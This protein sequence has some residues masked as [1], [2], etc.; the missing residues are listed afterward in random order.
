[1]SP[2]M[3]LNR[4]VE[5]TSRMSAV[6]R[7]A[8]MPRP[9]GAP[10]S[11]EISRSRNKTAGSSWR[12]KE[13]PP[14]QSLATVIPSAERWRAFVHEALLV[15]CRPG[16]GLA[17]ANRR[18]HPRANAEHHQNS[19]PN[20]GSDDGCLGGADQITQRD[21]RIAFGDAVEANVLAWRQPGRQLAKRK[22]VGGDEPHAVLDAM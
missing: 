16:A 6:R 7:E 17:G 19:D 4:H 21:D 5:V 20:N 18:Y 13:K 22:R 8:D 14:V 3:A 9:L 11:D 1:M 15:G 10:R 12:V 2:L